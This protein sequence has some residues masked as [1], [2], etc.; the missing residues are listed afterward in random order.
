M[1]E[2]DNIFWMNKINTFLRFSFKFSQDVDKCL[3][4]SWLK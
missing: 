4:D 1:A 3:L 2:H